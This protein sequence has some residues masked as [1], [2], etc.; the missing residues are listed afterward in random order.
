MNEST[1]FTY[2]TLIGFKAPDDFVARFNRFSRNVGRNRSAVARYLIGQCLNAYE[3][4][5]AALNRIRN[6]IL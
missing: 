1:D 4:D 3:N 2:N 5:Q 6:E